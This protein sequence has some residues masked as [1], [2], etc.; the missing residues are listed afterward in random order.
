M[1]KSGII[2]LY[3]KFFPIIL[4][5][6]VHGF[7][8]AKGLDALGFQIFT[9]HNQEDGFTFSMRNIGTFFKALKN[10]KVAY[11]R[12]SLKHPYS[13][14]SV[15]Y[16]FK[17]FGKKLVLEF[18]A[19]FEELRFEGV[20]EATISKYKQHFR[21]LLSITSG[22]VVVSDA[23][24]QHLAQ[25]YQFHNVVVIP[26]G[27]ER[28]EKTEKPQT[29]AADSLQKF[30][31]TY[32]INIIWVANYEYIQ[33]LESVKEI[34]L[35]CEQ[36]SIGI[37]IV[38]VDNSE[39]GK[40]AKHFSGKH[41]SF[42]RNPHRSEIAYALTHAKAGFAY[43]D[44]Q[45]YAEIGLSFYNSPLKVYEYLAND[46]LVI[47]NLTQDDIP[48]TMGKLLD[49]NAPQVVIDSLISFSKSQDSYRTWQDVANET[50]KFLKSIE[51]TVAVSD[52]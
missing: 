15:A 14:N 9:A 42:L 31:S 3:K 49:G 10:S 40:L 6:D 22:V 34:S 7:N 36:A 41:I 26:N 24:K 52:D 12:V 45:K 19:P 33:G 28:F 38:I 16:L 51:S 17:L 39:G 29:L 5:A 20:Q 25:E 30:Y 46:L 13:V 8:L 1:D 43:Y 18:N 11:M 50:Q 35:L 44:T 48:Y 27:G 2:F 47:S 23:L 4:G 37:G 32:P 21:R